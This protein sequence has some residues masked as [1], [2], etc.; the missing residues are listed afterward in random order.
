MVDSITSLKIKLNGNKQQIFTYE[1]DS[2]VS[3]HDSLDTGAEQNHTRHV[4]VQDVREH[5]AGNSLNNQ[6]SHWR[7][8]TASGKKG[9]TQ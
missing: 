1:F 5:I 4:C 7:I 8:S 6:P 9:Y 2:L 3:Q